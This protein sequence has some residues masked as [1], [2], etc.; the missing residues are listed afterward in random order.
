MYYSRRSKRRSRR[1]YRSSPRYYY[2]TRPRFGYQIDS[3]SSRPAKRSFGATGYASPQG[4]AKR[5]RGGLR[6]RKRDIVEVEVDQ[7]PG[8]GSRLYDV[9]KNYAKAWG[10]VKAVQNGRYYAQEATGFNDWAMNKLQNYATDVALAAHRDAQA[11]KRLRSHV[12][13]IG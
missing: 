4:D 7:A 10:T 6:G 2:F 11:R 13:D 8:W 12:I 5:V 1:R 9:G 3:S